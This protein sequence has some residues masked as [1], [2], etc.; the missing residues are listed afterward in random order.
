MGNGPGG[1]ADYQRLFETYERSRAASSGSGSTTAST[2]TPELGYAYGGDF[3]EEL[4]DG[5]F[6]CDGLLFPDRTPSPGLIEYKKVIEPV[7]IEGDGADGTVTVTNGLRLRRPVPSGLHLVLRGRG[8][9]GRRRHADRAAAGARRVRGPEAARAA[10]HGRRAARR[11]GRSGACSPRTRA[12]AR[13]GHEVAWAQLPGRQRPPRPSVAATGRAARARRTG[14]PSARAS[15]TPAPAR[16]ATLG[17]VPSSGPRL[18]VWRAPT[19]NDDGAD[20]QPDARY[21]ALWRRLGL[22]RMQHRMDAVELGRRRADASAPG[23]RPPPRD[24]GLRRRLP[25]DRRTATGCGLT[26]SVGPEGDWPCPLPR[27]GRAPR[28][29]RRVRAGRPGSAAARARRTR[30][31]GRRPGSG[32]GTLSVDAM[33][34][35]Y[36]R[37]QENGARADVRWAELR[38]GRPGCGSRAIRRSGSPP[39]AGPASSWTRPRTSPTWRPATRSGSTST[40]ASTASAR[41]PA[42][43]AR[44]RSTTCAADRRSSRSC[45]R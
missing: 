21:G 22:H 20:W 9:D 14:S 29:A 35:P 41:S 37:P 25:L 12:W 5:N 13:A 28:A 23:S 38:A 39:G 17:G 8:R 40:T 34:T 10:R 1:L 32:A 18:D 43:R 16:C 36:V 44:C 31:P 26:V 7:R 24:L 42:A 27:L 30:T 6:V 33:Q 19:D 3:G 2:S 4:H 15:S 11:R 45:S